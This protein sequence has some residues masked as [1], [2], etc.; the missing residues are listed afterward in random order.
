MQGARHL[1][2]VGTQKD[3]YASGFHAL[4]DINLGHLFAGEIFALWVPKRRT[5]DDPH[6]ASSAGS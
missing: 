6:Q 5:Q 2:Y 4:M 1:G 3:L